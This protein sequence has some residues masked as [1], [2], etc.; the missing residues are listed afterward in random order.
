MSVPPLDAR[1]SSADAA[2]TAAARGAAIV[3][4]AL[5]REVVARLIRHNNLAIFLIVLAGLAAVAMVETQHLFPQLPAW[6]WLLTLLRIVLPLAA[7]AATG[8]ITSWSI[9]RLLA[10]LGQRPVTPAAATPTFYFAKL[11][12]IRLLLLCGLFSS[13]CL[14]FGH[15]T[16]DVILAVVPIVLLVVTRVNQHGPAVFAAFVHSQRAAAPPQNAG[17]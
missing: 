17:A 14:L 7:L 9:R 2:E 6:M 5:A 13:A 15:R 1:S 8:L 12:S 3:D 16:L 10:D 11:S 4:A